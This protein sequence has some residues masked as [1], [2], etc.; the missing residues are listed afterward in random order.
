MRLNTA[1]IQQRAIMAGSPFGNKNAI[2]NKLWSDT[3]RREIAQD[4]G[5]KSDRRQRG[6]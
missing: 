6:Y 2:K 4:T 5:D 3:L 1:I